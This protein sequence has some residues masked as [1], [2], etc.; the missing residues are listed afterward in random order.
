MGLFEKFFGGG[1]KKVSKEASE[2][3]GVHMPDLDI[4][5]DEKLR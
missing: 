2:T 3:R 5:V 4:P 1:K